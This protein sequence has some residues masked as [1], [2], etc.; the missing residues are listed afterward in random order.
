MSLSDFLDA[1]VKAH[2]GAATNATTP[3]FRHDS[4]TAEV[5]H[6]EAERNEEGG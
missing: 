6:I 1:K 3:R 2:R 5:M 4:S